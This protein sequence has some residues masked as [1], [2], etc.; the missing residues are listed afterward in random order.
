MRKFLAVAALVALCAGRTFGQ[1]QA[2]PAAPTG[3][4][5]V[6][7]IRLVTPHYEYVCDDSG[8]T[9]E[10]GRE[11]GLSPSALLTWTGLRP[12]N[13]MTQN[14][15]EREVLRTERRLSDSGLFYSVSVRVAPPIRKPSERTVVI[16]VS[17]GFSH[18]FSGGNAYVMYGRKALGGNRAAAFAY[19]GWNLLGFEYVHENLGNRGYTLEASV[20]SRDYLPSRCGVDDTEPRNDLSVRAGKFLSPDVT[21]A[22]GPGLVAVATTYD[23]EWSF[24]PFCEAV[25]RADRLG[26][27]PA[28][29]KWTL[30]SRAAW[31]PLDG[32]WKTRSTG[33]FTAVLAGDSRKAEGNKRSLELFLSASAGWMSEDAPSAIAFRLYDE[34]ALSVRSGYANE[35]LT[36][37][38]YALASTELRLDLGTFGFWSGFSVVP[39]V[40]LFGDAAVPSLGPAWDGTIFEAFGAGVRL[41]VPAPVFTDFCF[42]WG[43]NHEGNWRGSFFVR[44][45]N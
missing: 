36:L 31:F 11:A 21:I 7:R 28:W 9:L 44:A 29:A 8:G 34:E 12:G 15:F 43:T 27:A 14:D 6:A 45:G 22:F 33:T 2:L 10:S 18:R 30:D 16:T 35:E 41:K 38:S 13:T 19:A 37:Q 24:L 32:A 4:I 26:F 23:S 1:E 39:Q 20:F 40:F 5:R 17:D 3:E 25:L 42:S